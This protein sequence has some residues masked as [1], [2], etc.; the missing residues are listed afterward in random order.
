MPLMDETQF[1]KIVDSTRDK[2]RKMKRKPGQ[3]FMDLH[4]QTLA[5]ALRRLSPDDIAAFRERFWY[6]HGMAYRWDLW[7]A[8]YWLHGGCSDDGFIDFRTCVISLGKKLFFQVLD[9]PDSL[10]DIVDRPDAPYM[11]S[12]GFQYVA[13]KVFEEL[14]GEEMPPGK[15]YGPKNPTGKRIDHDD[16]EVMRRHFPKIVAKFPDMGD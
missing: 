3:D 2:A 16:D 13:S 5:E 8:A 11:Q 15:A 9:D 4:E 12:E 14:T 7:A 6:F 10:A 1:W